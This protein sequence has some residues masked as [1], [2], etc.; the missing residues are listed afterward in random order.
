MKTIERAGREPTGAPC[1]SV[2]HEVLLQPL[3]AFRRA[4][5]DG[6]LDLDPHHLL[7]RLVERQHRVVVH[8]K[9]PPVNLGLKHLRPR[10]H[11]VP[12]D[13]LLRRRCLRPRF[14]GRRCLRP[15]FTGG[16]TFGPGITSYRKMICCVVRHSCSTAS[17]SRLGTMYR[18]IAL[19]TPGPN[20]CRM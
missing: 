19:S 1:P 11:V 2:R 20:I 7:A 14:T 8:L 12:E 5:V 17:S 13:D 9:L 3:R 4:D 16:S 18:S 10:N 15:R 6:L